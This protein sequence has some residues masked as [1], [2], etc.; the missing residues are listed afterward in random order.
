MVVSFHSH[1]GQFCRHAKGTLEEVVREA[2]ARGFRAYGLTE[3][4]PRDRTEDLYP[5]EADLTPADLER[6]FGDFV[7]EARRLQKEFGDRIELLVGM[8]TEYI[9]ETSL[10]RSLEL[11][12][13]HS[14]D[15]IVGSVH[16]ILEIPIDFDEAT[17]ARAEAACLEAAGPAAGTGTEAAFRVY[18]DAQYRMLQVLKPAVVAHFDLI[19]LFRPDHPLSDEVWAR[20]RRNVEFIVQ[21]GGVFEI[22]TSGWRKGLAYAYPQRDILEHIVASKGQ[23]TLSDDSHGPLQVGTNYHRLA[24]YLEEVGA[25]EVRASPTRPGTIARQE[26]AAWIQSAAGAPDADGAK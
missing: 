3:H 19:R 13:K 24:R 16:H 23:L 25:A 17:L 14:L 26:I 15:Y 4:M 20:I 9:N 2:V 12:E 21:Y 11:V 18:F 6:T 1:S 5:E 10:E 7:S 22:N 8:E